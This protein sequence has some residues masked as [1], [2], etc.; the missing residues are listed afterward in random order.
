MIIRLFQSDEGYDSIELKVRPCR[1]P[2]NARPPYFVD[3]EQD[4]L[5]RAISA[6]FTFTDI[7]EICVVKEDAASKKKKVEQ[8]EEQE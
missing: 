8:D 1:I 6:L 4:S 7:K 5:C 2:S 3:P